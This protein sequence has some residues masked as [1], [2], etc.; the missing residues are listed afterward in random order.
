MVRKKIQNPGRK[1]VSDKDED[2]LE[3]EDDE[4]QDEEDDEDDEDDEEEDNKLTQADV[5]RIVRRAKGKARRMARKEMLK[6]L[7]VENIEALQE[8]VSK[9]TKP[10]AKK[11]DSEDEDD[12]EA[13]QKAEQAR[14]TS[15]RQ[16]KELELTRKIEG[17][18]VDKF[19]LKF[20]QAKRI[21]KLIEVDSNADDDEI[22]DAIEELQDDMPSL[23]DQGDEEEDD[24]DEDED[25]PARMKRSGR[26]NNQNRRDSSPARSPRRQRGKKVD[27]KTAARTLLHERHPKTKK[28]T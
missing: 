20:S 27:P 28:S 19:D 15:E 13:A 8:L 18:L 5:D 26:T 14:K 9:A 16:V 4:D 24:D 17:V 1:N 11:K 10:P 2:D 12:D 22:E 7:G 21:R 25:R 6:T 23:F 3:D